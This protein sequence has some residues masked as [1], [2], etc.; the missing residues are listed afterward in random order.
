MRNNEVH[1][2]AVIAVNI[3]ELSITDADGVRLS[4]NTPIVVP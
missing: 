2:I 4:A 3:P 1:A